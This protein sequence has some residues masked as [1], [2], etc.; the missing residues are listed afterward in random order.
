MF[1][2]WFMKWTMVVSSFSIG[3][4][5]I[6]VWEYRYIYISNVFYVNFLIAFFYFATHGETPS[7]IIQQILR[8]QS[9]SFFRLTRNH[10]MPRIDS[11]DHAEQRA[12]SK[13]LMSGFHI[14][15]A[16]IKD[17]NHCCQCTKWPIFMCFHLRFLLRFF[18]MIQ[19]FL[20]FIKKWGTHLDIA[21][22][23]LFLLCGFLYSQRFDFF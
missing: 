10:F 11:Y 2:Y 3:I 23:F 17:S 4:F 9:L 18:I 6:T 16:S 5:V 12:T 19:F 21:R 22:W 8:K 14:F 20:L 7:L 1:L 15:I 13:I